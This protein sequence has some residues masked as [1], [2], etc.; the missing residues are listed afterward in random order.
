MVAPT[1]VNVAYPSYTVTGVAQ[2]SLESRSGAIAVWS[3][4]PSANWVFEID[5]NGPGTVEIK[6]FNVA[7]QREAQFAAE[8]DGGHIRVE[9]E[10]G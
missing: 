6:F 5:R 1:T 2:I 8:L 7:T 4:T 3:V 9:S 10:G